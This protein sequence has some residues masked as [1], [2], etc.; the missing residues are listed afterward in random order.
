MGMKRRPFALDN[1]PP[2]VAHWCVK[3]HTGFRLSEEA[4]RLLD[5]LALRHSLNR[6]AVLDLLIR[7]AARQQ[8]IAAALRVQT[9]GQPETTERD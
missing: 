1:V 2:M 4:L 6:T 7:E 5:A 8:G 3:Q 9:A